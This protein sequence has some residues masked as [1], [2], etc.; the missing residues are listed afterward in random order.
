MNDFDTQFIF[1]HGFD[2]SKPSGVHG[3]Y[4]HRW[5]EDNFVFSE[6]VGKQI[7][8]P[9]ENR[10]I[11]SSLSGTRYRI[12]WWLILIVFLGVSARLI[13]LQIDRGGSFA[14]LAE[15]NRQRVIPIQSERGLIFDRNGVQLAENIPSFSLAVVP[16]DLPRKFEDRNLMV[17]RLAE[18]SNQTEESIAN[19]LEE[20]GA[21]SYES[22]VIKENL[23]YA[24]ALKIMI[25]AGELPGIQIQRGSK[26][27]YLNYNNDDSASSTPFAMSHILGYINK[28]DSSELRSLYGHGYYPSDSI[29][30]IGVEKSYEAELRGVFGRRKIEVNALGKGISVLSEEAPIPGKH[31]KLSIDLEMQKKLEQIIENSLVANHKKRASGIV[32]NPNNGEVLALVSLPAFDNN[33]FSGGISVED[34]NKYLNNEDHPLFN[35]SIAGLYPSG[36]TIKPAIAAAAL[37]AGIITP[38]SHFLSNGGLRIGAWFFPDWQAGGHGSTNVRRAIA[39]SVNTFF[40]YI[41]GGYG[42]FHGLGVEKL[43]AFLKEFGFSEKLGIDLPGENSGF[44][45]TIDWKEKAKDEQWYIGD[46]YNL[47]IGQGDLLVT[48]LQIAEMT[49][50]IAN[51]GSLFVP[52]LVK[53]LV[54]PLTNKESIKE[55]SIV[56]EKY[57]KAEYLNTVRLGMRDCVEYGSCR[58][59]STLPFKVAGKTGTAQWSKN[60]ENHAWFTSF[61]PFDKPQIV[62]SVLVEEGGE[63]SG[64]SVPVA[65]EFLKWWGLNR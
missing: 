19:V 58:L 27:N 33:D 11:G 59:L 3:K 8:L 15:Q 52:H 41:G 29:G 16:Q 21:Y 2:S 9:K 5:V 61:A 1:G 13:F 36:S 46:T 51:N 35:R 47:S 38:A 65:Y 18:L 10:H 39:W 12:F 55:P 34:Y 42:D 54:D 32:I 25:A 22:I 28:M 40:Y 56:R 7:P 37:Q 45:P 6:K 20:Y 23:D 43:V 49:S 63:G 4:R 60:K 48:P 57:F 62:L 64:I 14:A 31:L 30:K 53:S 44:I 17:K 50:A 26:R 24:S